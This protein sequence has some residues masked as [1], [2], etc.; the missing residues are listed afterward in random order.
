DL[1]GGG[2]ARGAPAAAMTPETTAA[3]TAAVASVTAAAAPVAAAVTPV[4]AAVT[5][6]AAAVTPVTAAVTPVTAA[7]APVSSD[8]VLAL[9]ER[10]RGQRAIDEVFWRRRIWPRQNPQQRP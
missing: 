8:R 7:V 10:V 1:L 5:P 9:D 4:A 6:V 3:V 2:L